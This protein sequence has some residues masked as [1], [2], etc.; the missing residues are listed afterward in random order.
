MDFDLTEAKRLDILTAVTNQLETVYN[1]PRKELVVSRAFDREAVKANAKTFS[2]EESNDPKEV[3]FHVIEGI[4]KQGVQVTHPSYFGLFNPRPSFP[5]VMADVIN[6]YLNPQLAAWSHASFAVEIEQLLIKEFG[7]KFGYQENNID[8]VFCVGGTESNLTSVL[9]AMQ[10]HFPNIAEEGLSSLKGKPIIYASTESHHSMQRA[11]RTAGLGINAIKEIPVD[12]NL[13][14][15]VDALRLQ[16]TED[17]AKGFQ[18]FMVVATA[19]TTGAGV[20]DD[21][22]KIAELCKAYKLWFHVDAA[23]GGGA[24]I[25]DLKHL[26][27]GIEKSDSITLDLHKWFSVPMATSIFLTSNSQ[28]L[29]QTFDVKTN[30]MPE[31]GNP[32]QVFDPYVKSLQWSRRFI[33][34]KIYLPLAVF[35]WEGYSKMF[36]QQIEM[37]N[38]LRTMLK[39]NDWIILNQSELPIICFTHPDIE[40]DQALVQK[41]VDEMNVSEKTWISSYPINGQLTLR[42]Q[43]INYATKEEDLEKFVRLLIEYKQKYSNSISDG[44]E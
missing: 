19:G 26:L 35:G 23:Y 1:N 2:F 21:L 18:P 38:K 3:M 25:T 17:A 43:I 14:M 41:L 40:N 44:N 22:D 42:A 28:I 5:S 32:S 11:A 10:K 12:K 7:K 20:F 29:S 6:S 8:G 16:I 37:G 31:D 30:Y 13:T 9:T 33:G 27:N 34:L 15:N 4:K 24:I 36:A 39:D